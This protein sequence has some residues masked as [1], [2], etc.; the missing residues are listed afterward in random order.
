[1]RLNKTDAMELS[2]RDLFFN[3]LYHWRS[4][5]VAVLIGAVL[6]GGYSFL[7]NLNGAEQASEDVVY[8]VRDNYELSNQIYEQLLKE[9]REYSENAVAMRINPYH[10]WFGDAAYAVVM[11][12]TDQNRITGLENASFLIA[13]VYSW[14]VPD[15][16]NAD[17]LKTIYG[18][19]EIEYIREMIDSPV[20]TGENLTG[21]GDGMF[22]LTIKGPERETVEKVMAFFE[23]ALQTASNGDIQ[24]MG[25]HRLVRVGCTIAERVL[26]DLL[27]QQESTAKRI[28]TWQKAITDNNTAI[29]KAPASSGTGGGK[30]SVKKFAV[31]GALLGLIASCAVWFI[32]YIT[33]GKLRDG[34]MLKNRI[35]IPVF[36]ELRHPKGR[37]PGKGFDGLIEKWEYRKDPADNGVRLDNISALIRERKDG[38]PILLTGTIPDARIAELRGSLAERLG[39]A[40]GIRSEGDFLSNSRAITEAAGAA[41]VILVEEKDVSRIRQIDNMAEKL[42]ISG[43]NV[44]GAIV[45]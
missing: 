8:S 37:R 43:A 29:A 11:E 16:T 9:G 24:Q 31:L 7:G 32:A 14:L 40:A 34:E 42:I 33:A 15:L 18:L 30:K 26:D 20:V 44:T 23:N 1:M 6:L 4:I 22:R 2:L 21:S 25:R 10:G 19:D 3:L 12:G 38:G 36:G 5:L 27:T 39:E 35:G 45:L 41:A 28:A 13:Q 17:E